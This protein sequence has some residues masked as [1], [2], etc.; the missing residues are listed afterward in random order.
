MTTRRI[1]LDDLPALLSRL[2][3]ETAKAV[4]A[5]LRSAALRAKSVVVQEIDR[6]Q[7]YPAVDSGR[8]RN[9]VEVNL[10][11]REIR[12]TAPHAGILEKGTRPFWPPLAP[13]LTWVVRKGLA[14]DEDEAYAVAKAVQ[15]KIAKEGIAPRHY[16]AKA[17]KKVQDEIV[18]AEVRSELRRL[19]DH[20]I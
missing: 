16:F 18:P 12:V 2:E 10:F 11:T 6:A 3:P 15:A 5:G 13:L 8:L 9:S 7:P 4:L 19:A 17:M 1:S 20:G 14:D